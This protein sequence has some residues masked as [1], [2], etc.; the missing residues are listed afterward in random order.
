MD[1]TEIKSLVEEGNRLTTAIR[2]EKADKT[3]VANMEAR[4]AD[5]LSQKSALE[6]RLSAIETAA[7][8]P[9]LVKGSEKADELKAAFVDFLRNPQDYAKKSA[10]EALSKKGIDVTTGANGAFA[11]PSQMGSD[12]VSIAKDFSPMRSLARV[13]TVGTSDYKEILS[14]GGAGFE[15]VGDLTTRAVTAT[16]TIAEIK[17]TFGEIAAR[18][19]VS[20]QALED[21]FYDV[22]GWLTTELGESFAQAE[23]AAFISGN[24][25]NK[26]TGL[27]NGT[28][29]STLASGNA[30]TLGS[31]P[32]AKL[33]DLV[34][35]VKGG[36][37]ANGTFLMNSA[38]LA[39]LVKVK[40]STGNFI[41]QPSLAAGV[42]S[43]LLGY[44]VV[45]D[46]NMPDIAA[47]A[48]PIVFGDFN[49]GYL[50]A[51]R[52]M[53]SMLVN[54]YKTSGLV[55][56]EARKRVG[57]IVKDGAALKA[58]VIAAS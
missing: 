57:G 17:P 51:D 1:I 24:G 55:E 58:L 54:P 2:E 46:E 47:N 20:N 6:A 39:A 40:D 14:L 38:T 27:L 26:P 49:R 36:Y 9:G 23:G 35:A 19:Q 33:I 34:V 48:K 32:F 10:Y 28:A 56:Y 30:S 43:T 44:R 53:I 11:V 13:V 18:A 37:R 7:N 3:T 5:V 29:V 16:P 52:T 41:Y 25:T 50:I 15:W 4:L 12:I 31:D 21:V 45:T 22:A 42:A 8:R